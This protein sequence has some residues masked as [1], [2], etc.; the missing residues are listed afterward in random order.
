MNVYTYHLRVILGVDAEGKE[1]QACVIRHTWGTQ[2]E[3]IRFAFKF[4]SDLD[5]RLV[6]IITEGE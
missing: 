5:V 6:T 4:L 1:I 3:A 2:H